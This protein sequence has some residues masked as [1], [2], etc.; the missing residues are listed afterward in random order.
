MTGTLSR[1]NAPEH[2]CQR[3]SLGNLFDRS[4][5]QRLTPTVRQEADRLLDDLAEGLRRG[6]ADFAS[7]VSERLP[8]ATVGAWLG[9]PPEDHSHILE[10]THDQVYAQELLPTGS[11]LAVSAAATARLRAYFTALVAGRRAEPREDVLTG[12]IHAWDALEPDRERADETLYRL[13]MFVT[14]AAL[15][16]TG[17]LLSSMT[18]LLAE[19]GRWAWLRSH[20]EHVDA[21]VEEVLRYDPPIHFNTRIAARDT[22]LAGV[23]IPKDGMVHVLYGAASHDPRRNPDPET[24]DIG[25]GGGHLAFGSGVHY[26]LGAAL[27]KLE[28]RTLLTRMLERFATLHTVTPPVYAA[29]MVFR[30]VTS[31]GVA[32]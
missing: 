19:P 10:M 16:T 8:I 7:I 22:V 26:C 9:I 18:S 32:L 15:E 3:R 4:A 24:F 30:R 1:L 17:T 14:I 6:E 28:A 29:R 31:L 12:W 23:P 20:P 2:T 13:V 21:A 5:L 11:Q 25:R 27:A